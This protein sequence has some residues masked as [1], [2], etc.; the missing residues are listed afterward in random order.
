MP[1]PS[2]SENDLSGSPVALPH[3]PLLSGLTPQ[4]KFAV[5]AG[6]DDYHERIAA[7]AGLKRGDV[8]LEIPDPNLG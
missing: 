8:P 5:A 6:R 1:H 2:S 3:Q 4:E 7:M